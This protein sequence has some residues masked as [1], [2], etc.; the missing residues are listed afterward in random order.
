MQTKKGIDDGERFFQ[1]S[2]LL[3]ARVYRPKRSRA[4]APLLSMEM[5]HGLWIMSVVSAESGRSAEIVA[6]HGA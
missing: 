3:V 6:G 5:I 4:A 1:Y 2:R